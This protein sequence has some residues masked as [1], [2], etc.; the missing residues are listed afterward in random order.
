[1]AEHLL[2]PIELLHKA[3]HDGD[4]HLMVHY[5]RLGVPADARAARDHANALHVAAQSGNAEA[6]RTLLALKPVA[7]NI[8]SQKVNGDCALKISAEL[9]HTGLFS[10]ASR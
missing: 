9:G 7:P 5:L 6:M 2:T 8:N 1:M 10:L 3:I 4:L